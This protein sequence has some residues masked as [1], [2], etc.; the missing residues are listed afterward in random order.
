LTDCEEELRQTSGARDRQAL[1]REAKEQQ[2]L[3][4][5]HHSS[6]DDAVS[7]G[8]MGAS[9]SLLPTTGGAGLPHVV[10]D[11]EFAITH[12]LLLAIRRQ[13]L[14]LADFQRQVRD[15]REKD[16]EMLLGLLGQTL[17]PRPPHPH[18]SHSPPDTHI[19]THT[20]DSLRREV[21]GLKARLSSTSLEL[22]LARE[23]TNYAR[24]RSEQ[25]QVVAHYRSFVASYPPSS[26]SI[27]SIHQIDSPVAL[28]VALLHMFP[29]AGCC[30][31]HTIPPSSG[32]KASTA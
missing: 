13:E 7:A 5:A 17:A 16:M 32:C 3:Y 19:H 9:S 22:S 25:L 28:F 10:S 15:H 29:F 26:S 1:I 21:A 6:D 2:D 4:K 23:Q 18:S 11:E 8:V 30:F 24:D 27:A 31:A 14:E 20:L 12:R